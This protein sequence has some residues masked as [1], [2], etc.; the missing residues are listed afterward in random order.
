MLKARAVTPITVR[1]GTTQ[2]F[3]WPILRAGQRVPLDGWTVRAQVRA[4][5]DSE[6]V[7]HEFSTTAGSAR[8]EN[9]YVIIESSVDSEDWTWENG[10][11]D[12]HAT[13]PEGHILA[14]AEGSIRVRRSVTR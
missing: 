14:V 2:Q 4:T 11:Y 3:G 5:V 1:R 12:V 8:T 6:D 9:G 13:D 7:L 10:V